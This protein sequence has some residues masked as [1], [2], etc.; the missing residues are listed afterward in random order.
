MMYG[1]G[2]WKGV[3]ILGGLWDVLVRLGLAGEVLA[4]L[5][6]YVWASDFG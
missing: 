4:H 3:G 6:G 1:D 5:P 2:D